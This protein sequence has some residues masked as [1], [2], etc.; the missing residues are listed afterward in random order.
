MAF[1]GDGTMAPPSAGTLRGMAD[2]DHPSVT[3]FQP[4]AGWLPVAS[5]S[6]D[7][8][9]WGPPEQG[10]EATEAR[11]FACEQCGATTSYDPSQGALAC[12][13]CGHAAPVQ[14]RAG[15]EIGEFTAEALAAAEQGWGVDRQALHCDACGA[16]IAVEAGQLATSCPFCASNHVDLRAV[17]AG[18]LRPQQVLPFRLTGAEAASQAGEWL[19]SGW[20]HPS[21]LAQVARVDRFQGVYLPWWLFDARMTV[22]WRCEVGITTTTTY[23]DSSGRRRTRT[24]TRWHWESGRLQQAYD[25]VPIAG[26]TKL[27]GL[28]RVGAFPARELVPYTPELLAGFGAQ[29]YDVSL[30]DA[31]DEG[32]HT[33]RERV[34]G[35]CKAAAG[36]DKQRNLSLSADL[37]DEAW[38]YA[39]LPVYV[40]AYTFRDRT[41]VVMVNGATGEVGGQRPVAWWKVYLAMSAMVAPGLFTGLCLGVPG[42]LFAGIGLVFLVV[43]AV[44]LLLGVVFAVR[45]YRHAVQEEQL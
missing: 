8:Q 35:S 45:T 12:G 29:A 33:M 14:A 43:A 41:W 25:K 19:G 42:L 15:G 4:P 5:A 17:T 31:W 37:H 21:D 30:P 36:G 44:L 3:R 11:R 2:F 39:L 7:V 9:A 40:S 27:A 13:H 10:E 26:T 1:S 22:D 18:A 6:S 28:D 32:R 20:K 38:T 16:E 34:A 23:T 24:T